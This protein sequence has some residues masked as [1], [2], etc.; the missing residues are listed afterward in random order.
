MSVNRTYLLE[1]FPYR[2]QDLVPASVQSLIQVDPLQGQRGCC[3]K[4][5]IEGREA[6]PTAVD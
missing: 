6:S 1:C 4:L 2:I 3:L 5:H